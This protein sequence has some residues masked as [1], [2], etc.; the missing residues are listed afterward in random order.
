MGSKHK[1]NTEPNR[2]ELDDCE[3]IKS[4]NGSLPD[5]VC[6]VCGDYLIMY[7]APYGWYATCLK[8]NIRWT[9]IT[10]DDYIVAEKYNP[11]VN[12]TR[13]RARTVH[14]PNARAVK[15]AAVSMSVHWDGKAPVI[16]RE[17]WDNGR[18]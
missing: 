7:N 2:V 16:T 13:P 8:D 6:P 12:A 9:R 10:L 11:I 4:Q 14:P 18:L 17:S 15:K 1:H 3:F 5:L